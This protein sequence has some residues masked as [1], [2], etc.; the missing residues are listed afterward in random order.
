MNKIRKSVAI[1]AASALFLT[2]CSRGQEGT[3]EPSVRASISFDLE[4]GGYVLSGGCEDGENMF[5]PYPV[6]TGDTF[7]LAYGGEGE[8][9]DLHGVT[10]RE[11]PQELG[12]T[13][14]VAATSDGQLF[15]TG[16]NAGY[17]TSIDYPGPYELLLQ[18]GADQVEPNPV[19]A[20]SDGRSGSTV[21]GSLFRNGTATDFTLKCVLAGD[22]P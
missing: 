11:L 16:A 14:I 13:A 3:A 8:G 5:A 2:G 19:T 7:S 15:I 4:A 1:G 20:F 6:R 21:D 10:F 12:S 22:R 18:I 9:K 17:R